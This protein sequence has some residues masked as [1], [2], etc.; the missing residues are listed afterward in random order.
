MQRAAHVAR[1]A[2][3]AS[4][5]KELTL[6]RDALRQKQ[7]QADQDSAALRQNLQA[8]KEKGAGLKKLMQADEDVGRIGAGVPPIICVYA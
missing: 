5:E 6:E 1:L 2:S 3:L 4:R 7:L 8:E